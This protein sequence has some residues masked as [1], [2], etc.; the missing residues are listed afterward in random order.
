NATFNGEVL[1]TRQLA[2]DED[3]SSD[4]DNFFLGWVGSRFEPC[5]HRFFLLECIHWKLLLSR[6]V[7]FPVIF[8]SFVLPHVSSRTRSQNASS[9]SRNDGNAAPQPAYTLAQEKFT[10][11]RNFPLPLR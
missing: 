4:V 10:R 7:G 6:C 1:I 5:F 3:G 9:F 2:F 11:A 8:G